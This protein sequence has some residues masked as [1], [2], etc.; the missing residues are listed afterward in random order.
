MSEKSNH[1]PPPD[2]GMPD[3]GTGGSVA[4]QQK[5]HAWEHW[6][7]IWS[8]VFFTS[9]LLPIILFRVDQELGESAWRRVLLYGAAAI[10]VHLVG[11]WGLP[12]WGTH[13][14]ARPLYGILYSIALGL[15]TQA[16]LTV[17]PSFGLLYA[18]YF[19]QLFYA[20]P[21]RSAIPV[22][23]ASTVLFGVTSLD[24]PSLPALLQ[25][26]A[27]WLWILG[28]I[29]GSLISLWLNAIINQS[30]ERQALIERLHRAQAELARMERASGILE[31][32]QRLARE[33]HDT[34][35]QGLISII[36]HLET[37]DQALDS[38]P[39]HRNNATLQHHLKQAQNTARSNLREAR[40]VVQDLRPDVLV[41]QG[42]P[43]AMRRTVAAWQ[44][45]S[46]IAAAIYITGVVTPL[47]TEIEVTL[48]RVLQ[49]A[50]A[51]VAKH[52]HARQVNVT[53]SYMPDRILL[54][55]QDDGDGLHATTPDPQ[56]SMGFGLQSMRERVTSLGGTLN[57]ESE[58]GSGTTLVIEAPLTV[59]PN[60][61]PRP[62]SP[63]PPVTRDGL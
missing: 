1:A 53:L 62:T 27:L 12:R 63:V 17:H 50:L 29:C 31:E 25:H 32:R 15:I 35:A 10:A 2:M 13:L 54:D 60:P 19:T 23:M 46:G 61:T 34:L 9:L 56:H 16:L 8:V 33:I 3:V 7:W 22:A 37:A 39:A 52:A 57:L 41:N 14:G 49:E 26:P 42:L 36:T 58:P 11:F 18:G 21:A 28:G 48:I 4:A 5:R 44:V 30:A 24:A 55:V 43:D 59:Q 51:N 40:R 38:D 47:A 20:L 6:G 45:D